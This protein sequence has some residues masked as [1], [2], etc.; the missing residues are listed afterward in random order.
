VV[1][2]QPKLHSKG[3]H[4]IAF[5]VHADNDT[6]ITPVLTPVTPTETSEAQIFILDS[7]K[8]KKKKKKK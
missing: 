2:E 6:L 4:S 7:I 3:R 1:P 8:S 5:F